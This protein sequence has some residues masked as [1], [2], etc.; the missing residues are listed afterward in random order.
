MDSLKLKLH[1][2]GQRIKYMTRTC[3]LSKLLY[4]K[5]KK[6]LFEKSQWLNSLN[7]ITE[8]VKLEKSRLLSCK[9][10]GNCRE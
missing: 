8:W 10:N 1:F 9:W 6:A 5:I 3:L 2:L 4:K 7:H